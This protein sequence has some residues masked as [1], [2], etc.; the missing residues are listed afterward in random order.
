MLV[1]HNIYNLLDRRAPGKAREVKIVGMKRN[2][3]VFMLLALGII[4]LWRTRALLTLA[5]AFILGAHS[6]QL[7]LCLHIALQEMKT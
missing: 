4:L 1:P 7:S 2:A 5:I 6:M 3:V